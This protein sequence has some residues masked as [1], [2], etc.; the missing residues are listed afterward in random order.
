MRQ[1][2]SNL[3][4]KGWLADAIK[5]TILIYCFVAISSVCLEVNAYASQAF[6]HGE[7]PKK[8]CFSWQ[9]KNTEHF[10]VMYKDRYFDPEPVLKN[11]TAK[12]DIQPIISGIKI[13]LFIVDD[14]SYTI[15]G[16]KIIHASDERVLRHELAHVL[17]L[18]LNR[19]APMSLAEGIAIYAEAQEQVHIPPVD[20]K[21]LIAAENDFRRV[22]KTSSSR[23]IYGIQANRSTEK[24]LYS[25]GFCFVN[26][27]ISKRGIEAFKEFYK[28]C[29]SV[30]SLQRAWDGVYGK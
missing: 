1:D 3:K 17:F 19:N 27:I 8:P 5:N 9:V 21:E 18:Q 22:S 29:H 20:V 10:V 2:R 7:K 28:K 4:N 13:K 14:L 30:E 23:S 24:Q 25:K 16:T 11:L 6:Y 15:V 26:S 12:F